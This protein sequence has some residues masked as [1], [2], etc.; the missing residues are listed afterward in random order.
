MTFVQ[1]KRLRAT[2]N[3]PMSSFLVIPRRAVVAGLLLSAAAALP[4]AGQEWPQWGGPERDF[5]IADASLAA[6]WP[7]DGPPQRWHRPLGEGYSAIVVSGDRLYTMYRRRDDEE[8]VIALAA[9]DGE[10]VWEH[11]YEVDLG[12]LRLGY[13]KGPHSTPLIA[14]SRVFAAGTAGTL[15]VL[16]ATNGEPLWSHELWGAMG[17]NEIARGYGASPI[18]YRDTVILPVGGAG[19]GV[20]A[21]AQEDGRV[22]WKSQDFEASQ[23]SPILIEVAGHQQL[24]IFVA[25][26]VAALD[27]A[28]GESLWQHPH[29]ST[30][31]Y[32]VSTPVW[33]AGDLLF[34]SS[35]YGSGSRIL[36]LAYEGEQ[37]TVEELWHTTRM[38]VHFTNAV[39]IGDHIYATTGQTGAKMLAAVDVHGGELAWRDRSVGRSNLVVAGD[40]TL[41]LEEDGR[42]LLTELSPEGIT[43]LAE[44][45]LFDDRSWTVPTLVGHVL[46]ARDEKSI[47]ALELPTATEEKP[48]PD[49]A[50]E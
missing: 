11:R 35:A 32:N 46:Y 3:S 2:Y 7:A 34:T 25:D 37:P 49:G 8:I 45:Q 19:S 26:T 13:G 38:K 9:A 14:D 10:T 22:V 21:F 16:D 20:V 30:A 1:D 15:S 4:A 17:G 36:R 28:T 23:S 47:V 41:V 18:A 27:P 43:L 12:G 42:L 29:R 5:R 39:R 50:T 24:V 6:A 31:V 48:S 40:K 44:T 33:G